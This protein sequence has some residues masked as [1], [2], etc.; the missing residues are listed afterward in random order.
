[1]VSDLT[2]SSNRKTAYSL[3]YL[4]MNIGFALG[5]MLAGFL[6]YHYLIWLFW[7]DAITTILA[8]LLVAY[9]VPETR[10]HAISDCE[11]AED[12]PVNEQAVTGGLIRALLKRP[13]LLLSSFL[14]M[15]YSFVYAQQVFALPL[16][17]NSLFGTNGPTIFGILMSINAVTVVVLTPGILTL[18]VRLK[19]TISMGMGGMFYA[20]GFGMIYFC[21]ST[22]LFVVST[23]A[24]TVGEI[25]VTT[26]SGVLIAD[27]SPISHRAR[28]NATLNMI[29][30][31][32]ASLSPWLSGI[33]VEHTALNWM[34][35]LSF[36]L[37]LGA[38]LVMFNLQN[39]ST[40]KRKAVKLG[41]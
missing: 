17:L 32:G 13:L 28:F 24:W 22:L 40:I 21:H 33:I 25:L 10:G 8:S 5:P 2:V 26:N 4:G 19:S 16:Q 18:T 6:F 3:L 15:I 12:L 1:M 35:I 14:L 41:M 20:L 38:S 29:S 11:A 39:E 27:N 7:G 36:G 31:A 9:F 23:I 34:W 30:R 37:A